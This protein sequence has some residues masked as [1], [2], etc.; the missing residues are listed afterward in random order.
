MSKR[1]KKAYATTIIHGEDGPTAVFVAG[2]C[3]GRREKLSV[4]QSI[5]MGLIV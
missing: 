5:N 2:N 4:R 1:S 3:E